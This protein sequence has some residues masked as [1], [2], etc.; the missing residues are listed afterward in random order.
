MGGIC[1]AYGEMRS[2]YTILFGK[3]E[4]ERQLGRPRRRYECN[5]KMNLRGIGFWG[6]DWISLAED[7][8]RLRTILNTTTSLGAP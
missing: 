3:P 8:V 1:S 2:A 6:V 5:V 4:W 7:R